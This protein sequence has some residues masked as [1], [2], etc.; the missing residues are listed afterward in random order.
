MLS[1]YELSANGENTLM[2]ILFSEK[3]ILIFFNTYLGS[4]YENLLIGSRVSA[5]ARRNR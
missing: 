1:K 4:T 2:V 3:S 5:R